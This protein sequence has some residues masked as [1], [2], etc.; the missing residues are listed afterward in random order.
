MTTTYSSNFQ[1]KNEKNCT[2][3]TFT[4]R[5]YHK[6]FVGNVANHETQIMRE[7]GLA[8]GRVL[9]NAT[10]VAC[11]GKRVKVI[12]KRSVGINPRRLV[13]MRKVPLKT[14]YTDKTRKVETV[15]SAVNYAPAFAG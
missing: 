3:I 4:S 11:S 5:F 14:L 6:V 13:T 7:Q 8:D 12:Y 9:R 10:K 15:L 2:T 1:Q